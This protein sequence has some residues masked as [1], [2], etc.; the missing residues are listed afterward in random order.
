MQSSL[1]KI[2]GVMPF[3]L[4]GFINAFVDLGHKIIIQNS[5]YK[6]YTGDTQLFLTAIVNALMLLPFI[7]LLTPSGFLADKFPKNIVMKVSAWVSVI[8]TIIICFA[9]FMGF[10]WF[11]FAMTFLMGIQ[12]AIYSPSKYG[13]IKEL[14]GKDMLAMGNGAIAAVSIVAILAGMSVFSL[15]FEMMFASSFPSAMSVGLESGEVLKSV[16]PLGFLLIA[17]A[18]LELWLAYKL[19][20]IKQTDTNL[21]FNT[22]DYLT[23]RLLAQNLNLVFK[24]KIIWLCI[25]GVALFWSISQLYLVAFPNY[26]KNTL[27]EL[28]TFYVQAT[29]AFSGVGVIVGSI[30]A[31]RF[32]KHYIELGLI[33]FGALGVFI[34]T[35]LAPFFNSLIVYGVIF[36]CSKLY[37]SHKRY[38]E[39]RPT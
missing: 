20:Q 34:C 26:A 8:F 17:F 30:I 35:L 4:V 10:F 29:M 12:S 13:F 5:I 38:G 15:S 3:L 27:L 21:R 1:L 33:P 16:A 25:V 22:K 28:N 36:F 7:L 2:Y 39:K 37:Q 24:D 19:P 18:C 23:G 6:V 14:V 32:S 11:A 31:G 9:Y